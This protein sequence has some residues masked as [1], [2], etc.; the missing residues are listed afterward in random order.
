MQ[1]HILNSYAKIL[2]LNEATKVMSEKL[3]GN[4]IDDAHKK[5]EAIRALELQVND[6]KAEQKEMHEQIITLLG[7]Q[8]IDQSRGKKATATVTKAVVPHVKNWDSFHRY[9]KKNNAFYLL[10][11]RAAVVAYRDTLEV[12]RN[13]PIPG[14]ESVEKITLSLRSR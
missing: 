2:P 3:L 4:L 9:I 14:V 11:R 12:R 13:R 8:D 10:E 7:Q 1:G 6:L 5:R